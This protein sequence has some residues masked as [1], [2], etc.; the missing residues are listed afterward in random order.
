MQIFYTV[1]KGDTL[2][3]IASRWQVPVESLVYM[4]HIREPNLLQIGSQLSMPM[5]ITSYVVKPGDTLFKISR[6]C[7]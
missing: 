6:L 3:N 5:G 7:Q 4:N 2:Y 1:R